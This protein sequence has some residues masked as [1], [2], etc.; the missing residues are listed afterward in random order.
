MAG[1]PLNPTNRYIPQGTRE[2]LW[3]PDGGIANMA[4]PT[5]VEL[6]AGTNLTHEIADF[7]GWSQASDFVDAADLGSRVV[8]QIPGIIKI[9]ASTLSFWADDASNDIR[10][11][12]PQDTR[13]YIVHFPEGDGP[14]HGGPGTRMDVWKVQVG[15]ES[16][17]GKIVDPSQR[18]VSFGILT[19]PK[20]NVLIPAA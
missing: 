18:M 3:V 15:S 4:S 5:R 17:E 14:A 20:V 16:V 13:G 6:E 1:T 7:A 8:P 10:T 2:F 12:L 11:V 9:A 19:Q